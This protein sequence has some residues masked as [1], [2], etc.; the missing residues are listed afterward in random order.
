MFE[1]GSAS[2][3]ILIRAAVGVVFLSEG[4]L[5]FL[6]PSEQ[7]AG[8]FTTI[9]IPAPEFFG[10]LAGVTETLCGALILVGLLTRIAAVPLLI[11]MVLALALT[12]VPILWG[13]SAD[14]PK[15]DG[16]WDM[17]HEARLDWTLLL[18]ST[19]LLA[20]GPGRW[21]LDAVIARRTTTSPR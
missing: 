20:T 11:D 16:F 8:R 5:K 15:A 14:K 2:A 1:P 10:P 19:F 21:S 7:A 18:C 13:R 9:G 12:K 17:M 4:I 3:A 6:R